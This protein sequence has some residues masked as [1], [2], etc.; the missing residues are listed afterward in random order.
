M[1]PLWLLSAVRWLFFSVWTS[2]SGLLDKYRSL[3]KNAG[4]ACVEWSVVSFTVI[5]QHVDCF[6][7]LWQLASTLRRVYE[8]S[9]EGWWGEGSLHDHASSIEIGCNHDEELHSTCRPV[10]TQRLF[11]ILHRLEMYRCPPRHHIHGNYVCS[12]SGTEMAN[13]SKAMAS[14]LR[15]G[16][17]QLQTSCAWKFHLIWYAV[18]S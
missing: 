14:V 8:S 6:Q 11:I 3:F 9:A 16:Q 15:R 13:C 4:F 1:S 12:E 10:L 2:Y 5:L 17:L 18:R 7:A